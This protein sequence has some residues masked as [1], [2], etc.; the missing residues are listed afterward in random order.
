MFP[1]MRSRIAIPAPAWRISLPE[2]RMDAAHRHPQ[3]SCEMSRERLIRELMSK[4][5]ASTESKLM[6]ALQDLGLVA[7]EA[8]MIYDCADR[9]LIAALQK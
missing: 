5:G 6:D 2:V 1:V 4:F 3:D 8:V 7:D 9:D